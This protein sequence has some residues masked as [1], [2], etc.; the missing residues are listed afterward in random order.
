MLRNL[1][2]L[3]LR[4][5]TVVALSIAVLAILGVFMSYEMERFRV[6]RLGELRANAENLANLYAGAIAN[7][8]WEFDRDNAKAQLEALKVVDGFQRA[9]VWE[10][11]G[12]E[13][14]AVFH[15]IADGPHVEGKARIVVNGKEIAWIL[16]RL[17]RKVVSDAA[18]RHLREM[19]FTF[20]ALSVALLS[21][22]F[23]ALHF[24]AR[25]LERMTNL[26]QRFA[27]G[28]LAGQIPYV[29]RNDEVGRMAQALAVFRDHAI[30]RR[31]AEL[32]LRRRSEEL[33]A[34]NHDLLKARDAAESAN[35]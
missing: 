4:T 31:N 7:S 30:E 14:V 9:V 2:A 1:P 17:S 23:A 34:L 22:V 12:P 26:M 29:T 27:T 18:E 15:R 28:Q 16:V 19:L 21:A 10:S 8:V 11:N 25:P 33:V 24:L 6:S 32:A 20:G 3:G 35:R 13:F 5:K